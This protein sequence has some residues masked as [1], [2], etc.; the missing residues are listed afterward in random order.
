MA[1]IHDRG[2]ALGIKMLAP[3]PSGKG[4]PL[5]L[6]VT[7][8]GVRDPA[9][10]TKPPDSVAVYTGSGLRSYFAARDIDGVRVLQ[11]DHRL[12]VSPVLANGADMPAPKPGHQMQFNGGPWL[13]VVTC[14]HWDYAGVNC[15]FDVQVRV[16]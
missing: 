14:K 3:R 8:T 15:G 4:A 5:A 10:G 6:R 9:T 2:R 11:T 16:M 7:T 1:D 13:Q 12:L